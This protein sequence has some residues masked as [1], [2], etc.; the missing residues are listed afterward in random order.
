MSKSEEAPVAQAFISNEIQRERKN[1]AITKVFERLYL[2]DADDADGLT[3]TNPF[4][5]TAVVNVSIEVNQQRQNGIKYVH[6]PLDESEWILPRRFERI[7]TEI[8][9]LVRAGSVLVHC[10]AGVSRS[11]VIVALYMNEVGYKNFEDSLSELKRLRT[12]V[13]PSA[14]I[15][16]R[17]KS[18]LEEI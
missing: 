6:F 1:M 5:I 8:G 14:L 7:L 17:A 10:G 11:P 15:I 12:V 13:A 4:G 18:Y 16:E 2:G 3:L 9:K